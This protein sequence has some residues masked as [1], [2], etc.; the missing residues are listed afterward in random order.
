MVRPVTDLAV[1]EHV[2]VSGTRIAYR[3]RRGDGPTTLFVHGVP[4]D[5]RQWR[6]F[7]DGHAGDAIAVDLPGFGA[8]ER[9]PASEFDY[10]IGGL[11]RALDGFADAVGLGAYRLVVQDWGVL[12]LVAA[13]A[14]PERLERL[15]VMNSVPIVPGYRWHR[16]ARIWRTRRAGELFF[17]ATTRALVALS[18]REARPGFRPMPAGFVDMV[19]GNVRDP[20]TQ[21]AILSLYRSSDPSALAAAG[22][23]LE[24]VG[25]PALVLWG[26]DDPFISAR[27]AAEF[28]TR[29]PDAEVAVIPDAGHWPWIDRADVVER[30]LAFLSDGRSDLD[31]QA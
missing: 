10:S 13:L 5:S 2:L 11:S 9:P 7:L 31:S 17:A 15:V 26:R 14:E 23:G 28:A 3:R 29:L 21:G 19:W 8:S 18:L 22:A 20:A 25:C 27:F 24:R 1:V 6:P 16:T 4:T 12:G 30:T